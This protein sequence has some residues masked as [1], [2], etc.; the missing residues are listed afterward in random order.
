M[1]IYRGT[2]T[3]TKKARIKTKSDSADKSTINESKD[4]S[5]FKPLFDDD[6]MTKLI[7]ELRLSGL[8]YLTIVQ[9]AR[10][11]ALLKLMSNEISQQE[12]DNNN[13]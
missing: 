10:C 11:N 6:T 2:S 7:P 13:D 12:E 5:S 8:A 3:R 4:N 9:L 1:I